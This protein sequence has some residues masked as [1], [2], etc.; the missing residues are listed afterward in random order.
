M[1]DR[2]RE[3]SPQTYARVAGLLYLINIVAG[4]VGEMF[5]RSSMIVSG[6]AATTAAH[7]AKSPELWRIGIA[8][9]LIMHVTDVP[10]MMIFYVLFK[11]VN[12]NLALMAIL[13]TLVQ[14]AVAVANKMNL[15]L[16]LFLSANVEYLKVFTP[17]QLHALAY[18]A[19]KAHGHGFG[20]ALIFFGFE[21]LITGYLIFKSGFLP[22]ALGLAIQAAGVC[23]LINSFALILAPAVADYLFPAILLPCFFAELSLCLWLLVKGI[24]VSKWQATT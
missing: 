20:I 1:V 4:A 14:T 24:D 2:S 9:D 7:I 16:P 22:R 18:I 5:V 12:K 23:Y 21:C 11:R 8:G 3:F 10:L 15:M 19:I 13:F 6:N 17:D